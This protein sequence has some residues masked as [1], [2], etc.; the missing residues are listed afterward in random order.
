MG[1]AC[2]LVIVTTKLWNMKSLLWVVACKGGW[3]PSHVRR[4]FFSEEA[5]FCLIG[6][7]H[8]Q[9]TLTWLTENPHAAHDTRFY[10]LKIRVWCAVSC[11]RIVG[12]IVFEDTIYLECYIDIVHLFLGHL[13][14]EDNCWIIIPTRHHNMS[15]S[16]SDY[17]QVILVQR[18]NY[19]KM[20]GPHALQISHHQ[21][22]FYGV[23]LKTS[24]LQES[25]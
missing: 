21:V 22:F 10:P 3:W 6:C 5:W 17:S 7:V 20:S 25:M 14:E 9:N 1:S 24:L 16:M 12:P 13:T 23:T 19:F 2:Y 18:S 4:D 11:C 15:Y 8:C